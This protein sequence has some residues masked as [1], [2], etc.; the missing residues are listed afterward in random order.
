MTSFFKIER[1]NS[2]VNAPEVL[3]LMLKLKLKLRLK[4]TSGFLQKPSENQK[5][6]KIADILKSRIMN[7]LSAEPVWRSSYAT[8]CKSVLP[9]CKSQSRLHFFFNT[10]KPID[11]R[12]KEQNLV[13]MERRTRLYSCPEVQ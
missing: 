12:Y 4:L 13:G 3:P 9:G 10:F 1:E 7:V 6:A 11:L 8:D 2:R 5:F